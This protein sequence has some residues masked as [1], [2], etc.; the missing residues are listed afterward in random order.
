MKTHVRLI[1]MENQ[2]FLF[3]SMISR[4]LTGYQCDRN[5]LLRS[6]SRALLIRVAL[7]N[8]V[9]KPLYN[10]WYSL[11]FSSFNEC[12]TRLKTIQSITAR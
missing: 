7:P 9:K 12:E 11:S 8:F 5:V 2:E 3:I 6:K 1:L 4:V 10:S